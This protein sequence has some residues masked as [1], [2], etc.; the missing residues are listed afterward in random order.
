MKRNSG[1]T[2]IELLLV[3]AIIAILMGM[4][5][6]SAVI[7]RNQAYK[8][9]ARAETQQLMTAVKAIKM[10]SSDG[11]LPIPKEGK[12]NKET[13]EMFL[14]VKIDGEE[15]TRSYLEIPSSRLE[16]GGFLD[17]WGHAYEYSIEESGEKELPNE[18]Y[19]IAVSFPNAEIFYYKKD[20]IENE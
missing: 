9:Q 10:A 15:E 2:V 12:M 14:N 16:D 19:Q 20:T 13:V 17:P 1:F 4:V 3:I 7:A 5:G 6:T 8:A 11:P 18:V